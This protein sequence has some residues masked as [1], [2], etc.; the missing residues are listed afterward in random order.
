MR[1][2]TAKVV[3]GKVV[4][5]A[6]LPEGARLTVFVHEADGDVELDAD[7]EAAIGIAMTE[8]RAG[9]HVTGAELR[10]FLRRP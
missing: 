5:R 2:V 3:K 10:A 7:D 1:A 4:T 6:K 8:L 9:K